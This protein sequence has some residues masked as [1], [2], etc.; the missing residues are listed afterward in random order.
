MNLKYRKGRL[1]DVQ[2]LKKLAVKSWTI[3]QNQLTIENW[4]VLSQTL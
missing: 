2:S 4:N 3:F 1:E